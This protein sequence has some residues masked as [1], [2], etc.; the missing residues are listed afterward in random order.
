MTVIQAKERSTVVIK[1]NPKDEDGSAVTPATGAWYFKDESGNAIT[2]S[3]STG[4]SLSSTMYATVY[5]A[6]LALDDENDNGIRYH[7]FIGTY[8]G[9]RGNGLAI[10][11]E[12]QVIINNQQ[13]AT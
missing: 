1:M 2:S 11:D 6:N 12:C 13:N 7:T 4:L 10:L 8:N 3:T 9:N 5:G